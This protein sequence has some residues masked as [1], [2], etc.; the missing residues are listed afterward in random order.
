MK[1]SI[2]VYS[3]HLLLGQLDRMSLLMF[4]RTV[5]DSVLTIT[6]HSSPWPGLQVYLL[7]MSL[8]MSV[9]N[10]MAPDI[11]YLQ[12][13]THLGEKSNYRSTMVLVR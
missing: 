5:L 11:Q 1:H 12:A 6:Q 13:T 7:D 2:L 8:D 4:Y 10:G 3:T 9:E